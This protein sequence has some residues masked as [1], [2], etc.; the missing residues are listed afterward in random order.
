MNNNEI[1]K[2]A[3]N[4]KGKADEYETHIFKIANIVSVC[5]SVVTCFGLI[6]LEY[7]LKGAFEVGYAVIVLWSIFAHHLVEVIKVRRAYT[8]ICG[9]FTFIMAIVSTVLY[10]VM[11]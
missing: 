9:I 1:L 4:D 8:I 5:V 3:Q 11:W 10:I 2:A 7:F 6:L